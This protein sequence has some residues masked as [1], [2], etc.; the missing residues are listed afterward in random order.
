MHIIIGTT[1]FP[2][3]THTDREIAR[4]ALAAHDRASAV[5]FAGV[6]TAPGEPTGDRVW[7]SGWI[8]DAGESASIDP[9]A[10]QAI[11]EEIEE[12]MFAEDVAEYLAGDPPS[13]DET[14]EEFCCARCN[15]SG[16]GYTDG[17]IC[18]RC[19]GAG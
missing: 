10:R 6:P 17:S 15:G 12:E 16:E 11:A 8:D 4:M 9:I 2:V 1:A 13:D 18:P 5:V 7:A 3:A 14:D 19:N